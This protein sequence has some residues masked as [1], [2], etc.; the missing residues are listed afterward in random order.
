MLCVRWAR[1][2]VPGDPPRPSSRKYLSI[3]RY[4]TPFCSP[5]KHFVVYLDWEECMGRNGEGEEGR[6]GD[7]PACVQSSR[8]TGISRVV[9]SFPY[10]SFRL[11]FPFDNLTGCLRCR[12]A[13]LFSDFWGD[14]CPGLLGSLL[15]AIQILIAISGSILCTILVN[16]SPTAREPCHVIYATL[17]LYCTHLWAHT[18]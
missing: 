9:W 18:A 8:V 1:I 5:T 14:G 2:D 13:S 3:I 7:E 4:F 10:I 12:V 11:F 6:R 17:G 16:L 15:F